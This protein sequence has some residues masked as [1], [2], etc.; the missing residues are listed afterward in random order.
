MLTLRDRGSCP[1]TVAQFCVAVVTS[2]KEVAGVLNEGTVS[3]DMPVALL[4]LI[5]LATGVSTLALSLI[6]WKDRKSGVERLL[7]AEV[8]DRRW[9]LKTA[10]EGALSPG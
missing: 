5:G 7:F 6:G 1:A 9:V 10:E 2:P 3:K 8:E 4:Q